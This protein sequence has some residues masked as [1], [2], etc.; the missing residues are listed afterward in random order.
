V[1]SQAEIEILFNLLLALIL[2]GVVG[3]E[4]ELA[5]RPAGLR[6]NILVCMGSVMFGMIATYGFQS[7]DSAARVVSNIIVGVGFLGSGAILKEEQ[8][9]H[10]LT[11]AATLWVVAGVGAAIAMRMYFLAVTS[12]LLVLITL[13]GLHRLEHHND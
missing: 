12:D 2:G 10:G 8:T 6:T 7:P 3:F 5:R 9:V 4:R 1:V 13:L 11:T